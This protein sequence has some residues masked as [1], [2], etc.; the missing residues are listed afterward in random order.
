[1]GRQAWG[2]LKGATALLLDLLALVQLILTHVL[3]FQ[4]C[5]IPFWSPVPCAL[6][7]TSLWTP[8]FRGG[9]GC[10]FNPSARTNPLSRY[11]KW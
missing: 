8:F 4:T 9:V 3:H 2:S 6:R 5:D 1:M 7:L 11:Q 10:A